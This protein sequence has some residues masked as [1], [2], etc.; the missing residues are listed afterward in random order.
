MTRCSILYELS[1]SALRFE[2]LTSLEA[3][4]LRCVHFLTIRQTERHEH[5]TQHNELHPIYLH[6][7]KQHTDVKGTPCPRAAAIQN[8]IARS[9][10]PAVYGERA[11]QVSRIA[12]ERIENFVGESADLFELLD[13]LA[14]ERRSQS[15]RT[16]RPVFPFGNLDLNRLRLSK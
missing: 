7:A 5:G 9:Q 10:D 6:A 1:T 2:A 16:D 15:N 8:R 14:E 3:F 13:L 4:V 11:R 12:P